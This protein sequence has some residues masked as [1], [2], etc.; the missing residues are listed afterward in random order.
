M[1]VACSLSLG[2]LALQNY[3]SSKLTLEEGEVC[4]SQLGFWQAGK[5]D[6]TKNRPKQQ[7]MNSDLFSHFFCNNSG[8]VTACREMLG[9]RRRFVSPP[10][11]MTDVGGGRMFELSVHPSWTWHLKNT[12]R[13]IPQTWH[14]NNNS[15]KN[16][17]DFVVRGQRSRSPSPHIPVIR[18]FHYIWHKCPHELREDLIQICWSKVKG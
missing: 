9:Q 15:K 16:W 17:Q 12:V 1:C 2:L 3:H 8:L 11:L 10:T 18:V 6:K 5:K 4:K 7:R 13:G 14:N